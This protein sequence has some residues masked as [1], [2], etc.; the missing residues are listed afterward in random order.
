MA[1]RDATLALNRFNLRGA[2]IATHYPGLVQDMRQ[3]AAA[4]NAL[5]HDDFLKVQRANLAMSYGFSGSA[6]N[7][8]F[9]FANGLAI[10]PVQGTM[11]NRFNYSFGY[12]TGYN[13]VRAQLNAAL[14]DD[15]VEGIILDVNSYGG[16]AAG[17]FELADDIYAAR[18]EKPIMAVIDSN[19]YSAAYAIASAATKV[20]STPSGGA[21]SIG[22]VA[23][24]VDMSKMLED[25]G[26]NISFVY[27]GD[28]KV[29]G[30]PYEALSDDVRASIQAD[31]NASYEE[32]VSLVA[33][34][35]GM[36]SQKVRE[37]QAQ[38][39]RA[40]DALNLGLIDVVAKP[41]DAVTAFFSELSGSNNFNGNTTLESKKMELTDEQL[42]AEKQNA[43]KADRQRMTA[44]MGCDE[45]KGKSK[46][47]TH[48]AMNTDMDLEAAKSMLAASAPEVTSADPADPAAKQGG[49]EASAFHSAM[50]KSGGADVGAGA[51]DG[52]G[53]S[54]EQKGT[55]RLL[56]AHTKAT[57]RNHTASK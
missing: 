25:W 43:I 49:A 47:A 12:V 24:H 56:S 7:K 26:I 14:A 19:C 27:A 16:E 4:D 39:Y 23:M 21:G 55:S 28:H 46:L 36:D 1:Q 31:V 40:D 33:R 17:C 20:V 6:D 22:V 5:E 41:S 29:D 57:G 50:D 37:T 15:D 44:I 45:A 48:I 51:A 2:M 35:R 8:P 11:I 53:M 13:F 18:D 52:S 3:L 30:N 9:A 38:T 32:F 42:A 10:I 54:A 34:N